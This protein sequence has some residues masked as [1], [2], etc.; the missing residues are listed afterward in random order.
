MTS[1]K[2]AGA[3]KTEWKIAAGI[4]VF[5]LVLMVVFFASRP[6]PEETARAAFQQKEE[7]RK[8]KDEKRKEYLASVGHP[9]AKVLDDAALETCQR[10]LKRV[11]RDPE[12]AVIPAVGWVRGSADWRF[13]WNQD[14]R[15]VRMKNGLGLEVALR[16]LCVVDEMTGKIKLLTLD[17][18]VLIAPN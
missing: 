12:T 3:S 6:S 14:S 15:M 10:E 13:L 2:I 7:K 11:S 5:C 9:D 1:E 4:F 16:A 8:E 17:E 18:Q